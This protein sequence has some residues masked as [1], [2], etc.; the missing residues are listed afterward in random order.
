MATF[1][2]AT[3][4]AHRLEISVDFDRRMRKRESPLNAHQSI[5]FHLF[6][7]RVRSGGRV[8]QIAK[9]F[10]QLSASV[11]PICHATFHPLDRVF[12]RS[13]TQLSPNE[14]QAMD[15]MHTRLDGFRATALSIKLPNDPT[16]IRVHQA[17]E[18]FGIQF[19]N[20]AGIELSADWRNT[21]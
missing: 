17:A 7:W 10:D 13:L 3:L 14:M 2:P 20:N 4:F 1:V 15:L 19:K 5:A 18:L 11:S 6:R 21:L 8:F 12:G 16:C 9:R